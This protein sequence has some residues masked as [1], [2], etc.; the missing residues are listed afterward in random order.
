MRWTRSNEII[1][2]GQSIDRERPLA[3]ARPVAGAHGNRRSGV[4]RCASWPRAA[5]ICMAWRW[6]SVLEVSP[7][8]HFSEP[9]ASHLY[10][11][12]QEA[13]TNAARHGHASRVEIALSAARHAFL[14]CVSDDGEGLPKPAAPY[15]GMGLNIMKYRAGMIGARF[16]IV[17]RMPRGT[18]VRVTG[19]QSLRAAPNRPASI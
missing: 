6:T 9:D 11:I 2:A 16:E 4:R 18:V 12:A 19:E 3:G 1:G 17:S 15:V 7:E 5:A 8:V 13:L 14:L 10:R